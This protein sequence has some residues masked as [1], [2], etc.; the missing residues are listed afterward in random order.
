METVL[1]KKSR[2]KITNVVFY[3]T[4]FMVMALIQGCGSKD[5]GALLTYK[6]QMSSFYD[7]L[8]EYNTSINGIDPN[9]ESA[10]QDLLGYLDQVNETFKAMGE[11]TVPGEFSGIA[12][13]AVEAAD[14]MQKA[15][16]YYH[17]AYDG[18][19]D[20]QSEGTASQFYERAN[21]K[22]FIMLQVLHGEVPSGEGISVET[23]DSIE[24]STIDESTE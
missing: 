17:M 10:K 19:F 24:L 20:E 5:D 12:D 7:K 9:S 22:A 3:M 2:L 13:I 8:S 4:A 1:E 14:D 21:K 16:E 11:L 6:E 18:E 15:N 23:T